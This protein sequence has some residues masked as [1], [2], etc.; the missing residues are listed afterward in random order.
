MI[1][2]NNQNVLLLVN[3]PDDLVDFYCD[4]NDLLRSDSISEMINN[5]SPTQVLN[6]GTP[7]YNINLNLFTTTEIIITITILCNQLIDIDKFDLIKNQKIIKQDIE[8]IINKVGFVILG[9]NIRLSDFETIMLSV[10]DIMYYLRFNETL[11][12][13]V[14]QNI[15]AFVV[16]NFGNERKNLFAELI[17][18]NKRI[19]YKYK[20]GLL[21]L[22]PVFENLRYNFLLEPTYIYRP[23]TEQFELNNQLYYLLSSGAHYEY[24]KGNVFSI[25][26]NSNK[27][28]NGYIN[29]Y[30]EDNKYRLVYNLMI[31]NDCFNIFDREG[32]EYASGK[33][34]IDVMRSS[35]KNKIIDKTEI[36]T[37]FF[38]GVGDSYLVNSLSSSSTYDFYKYDQSTG[39]HSFSYVFYPKDQNLINNELTIRLN[40]I[41]NLLP[42]IDFFEIGNWKELQFNRYCE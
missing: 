8:P 32:I 7:V 29:Y 23:C 36:T 15:Y 19:D 24:N 37:I 38:D 4:R 6:D 25:N 31:S 17:I 33:L 42:L 11:K 10:I 18:R 2:S 20:L 12:S 27:Y 14:I 39:F 34:F 40:N 3:T 13:F 26:N 30:Y 28:I 1:Y 21:S 35:I 16:S 5:N 9:T 22:D 41:V